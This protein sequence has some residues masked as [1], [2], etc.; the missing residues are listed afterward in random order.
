MKLA[1]SKPTRT[2]EDTHLLMTRFR[3]VGYD[4]LQLKAGQ[5]A[6]YLGEPERFLMDWGRQ[7]GTASGL[8]AGM[9]DGGSVGELRRVFAFGR[10]VGAELVVLCFGLSREGQAADRLREHARLLSLMGLEAQDFGL[11][12]SLHNHVGHPVM[13]REDL[14]VFFEAVAEGSLGLTVDTAHLVKSGVE[15]VAGVIRDFAP[16]ID[17]FHLKDYADGE[18]KML[19]T[20]SI[21]FE[22]IFAAIA[23]IG[24]GGWL[25][26]D[27][28]SD[29][30]LLPAMEHC[31][32][33]M[34]AHMGE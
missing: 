32:A 10:V 24:Y 23:E 1:F 11:R 3:D 27:E 7:K 6:A 30:P 28:E 2:D 26:T 12:L 4:G 33:F 13:T 22:P 9:A 15:D 5:Y 31:L 17:N 34:R 19:G 21:D 16:F 18:W 14:E 25:S 20:G 8:I 29:A